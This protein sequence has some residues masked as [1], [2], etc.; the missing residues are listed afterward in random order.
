MTV[1]RAG[2]LHHKGHTARCTAV[3]DATPSAKCSAGTN[4]Y[5]RPELNCSFHQSLSQICDLLSGDDISLS[6]L[7]WAFGSRDRSCLCK[8]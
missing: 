3:R 8:G 6:L 5:T 1:S 7:S 4:R 2:A